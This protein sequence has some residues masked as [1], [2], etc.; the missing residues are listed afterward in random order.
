[1]EGVQVCTTDSGGGDADDSVGGLSYLGDGEGLDFHG[2]GLPVEF[3]G[4]HGLM[5]A[6]VGVRMLHIEGD[7]SL[8]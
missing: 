5:A 3:D 4:F 6:V 2:E 8:V 1:M 7:L